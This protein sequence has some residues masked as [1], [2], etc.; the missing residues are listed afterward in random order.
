M[1]LYSLICF[2]A[3]LSCNSGQS[4]NSKLDSTDVVINNNK[5][6]NNIQFCLFKC[7]N[8]ISF[9]K[10][11]EKTFYFQDSL[12]IGE[13]YVFSDTI[14]KLSINESTFLIEANANQYLYYLNPTD[15]FYVDYNQITETL[16]TSNNALKNSEIN[17]FKHLI[18]SHGK[19]YGFLPNFIRHK[20]VNNFTDFVQLQNKIDDLKKIRLRYLDS[21]LA[22]NNI[23]K[24]FFTIAVSVIK[25]AAFTDSLLLVSNNKEFLVNQ[26]K[27]A[28][29]LSDLKAS[30]QK[31]EFQYNFLYYFNATSLLSLE[32]FNKMIY[33]I[34]NTKDLVKKYN[35][36]NSNY[37]DQLRDFL[38]SRTIVEALRSG[39][40][41]PKSI[42]SNYENNCKTLVYSN[43][44]KKQL[45]IYNSILNYNGKEFLYAMNSNDV[46]NYDSIIK[47][48][49]GKLIYIDFWASWCVPCRQEMPFAKK[50]KAKYANREIYFMNISVDR[51]ID[52]WKKVSF[53]NDL[54]EY[55][56]FLFLNA[57]VS[58][59][60]KTLDVLSALPKY[61]L[62]DQNGKI[63]SLNAPRPSDKSL[64]DLFN[65]YLK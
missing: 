17:F 51:N 42:I 27:Y 64:E 38:L 6:V 43:L 40:E 49:S 39:I 23:S 21:V 45:S 32:V 37:Y 18:D 26:N 46:L 62:I 52:S 4:Q 35:Y 48:H 25:S 22:T 12:F 63:L 31:N 61:I 36:I 10:V 33:D 53:E 56:S 28:G 29:N 65:K 14:N 13:P 7:K 5:I 11:K 1:R 9:A 19:L 34:N 30:F 58:K 47:S 60:L 3:L 15:T 55:E 2:W 16:F 50:I 57:D 59:Y 44:V 41:V 24:N 20:K 8:S 54:N